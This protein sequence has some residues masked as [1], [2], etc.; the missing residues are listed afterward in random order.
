MSMPQGGESGQSWEAGS[1]PGSGTGPQSGAAG[2]GAGP[3]GGPQG[4]PYEQPGYGQPG[5][6]QPGQAQYGQPPSGPDAYRQQQ[7]AYG[8]GGAAMAGR[9]ISPVN[10]IETRVTGRRFVQ[11]VVDVIL[12]GIVFGLL[13]FAL[14]RGHGGIHAVLVLILV[15]VNIA[16][17]FLYW[18]YVPFARNG[19]TIGMTLMKIRVISASGGPASLVQLFIRSILL[20]LFPVWGALVGWIVMMF[21]RY[22]QRTGDHMAKTMVV[23]ADVAPERA[24]TEFAGAGQ[25]GTR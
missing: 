17:Y 15:L 22:R 19:Q 21:S 23:R 5:Y 13:S 25:A 11:Y 16:W 8:G 12:S 3:A 6:A 20:V 14:N 2:P 7:P 24:P 4:Q 18:A 9:P 10:E 1:E